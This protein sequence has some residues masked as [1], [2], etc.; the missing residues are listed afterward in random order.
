[1]SPAIILG[2]VTLRG[3]D[4]AAPPL[5]VYTTLSKSRPAFFP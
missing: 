3:N 2:A 5:I 4:P 1:M